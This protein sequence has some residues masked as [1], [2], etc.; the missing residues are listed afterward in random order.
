MNFPPPSERQAK[1]IWFAATGLAVAALAGLLVAAIWGLGRVLQ[2]LSPVLWPLAVAGVLAYLLDPVV[3]FLESRGMR[4][5]RAIIS[6]FVLAVLLIGAFF[7]SVVPQLVNETRQLTSQFPAY[8]QRTGQK[9]EKWVN[10][11]PPIIRRL[12]ERTT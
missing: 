11:P 1:V 8:A 6:V 10:N 7:G 5:P 9:L 2:V 12:L 4:R 3:D